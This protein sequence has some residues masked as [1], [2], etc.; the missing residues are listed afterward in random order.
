M[1]QTAENRII[2]EGQR[3]TIEDINEKVSRSDSPEWERNIYQLI[4]DW[5]SNDDYILQRTS[6]STG[7]PKK[8]KLKKKAMIASAL[9]T[10]EWFSLKP[11]ETAWLCLPV[12]YIAGKM[13]IVRA[14]IGKLNLL[15][16][17]PIGIP[18]IPCQ[19]VDFASMVPLQLKK[20]I[21]K[22]ADF[23]SI[24]KIIIGGAPIDYSLHKQVQEIACQVYATFGMTET[25]SH[26]ALQ[27]VNGINPD[28]HFKTLAGITV[29]SDENNCLTIK[30]PNLSDNLI[31]TTD[32]VEIIS[33]AE[34]KWLG[35]ADNVINSGGIKIFP[36][37]LE[38]IISSLIGSNC[39]IS[40]KTDATLGSRAVLVI[41]GTSPVM[42]TGLLLQKIASVVGKL[43]APKEVIYLEKF[44][45]N[46][47]MKID[48]KQVAHLISQINQ[49]FE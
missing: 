41:E 49:N 30:A 38:T 11:G 12:N 44:P 47:S 3:L 23:S 9:A 32:I 26:I 27:Q 39:I 20:L 46:S 37:E 14:I 33:P 16:S 8:I 42:D 13:M 18:E 21:D 19:K 17:E 25:C 6:G 4:L 15:I 29:N 48:R 43:K 22:K 34:F 5:F 31:Q 24:R 28:D 10:I 40:S 7:K 2:I 45:G 1:I 35:R 36:E